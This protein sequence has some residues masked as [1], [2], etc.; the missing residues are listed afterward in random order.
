[1]S[2][3]HVQDNL[4]PSEV[5]AHVARQGQNHVEPLEISISVQSRVALRSRRLQQPDALV[6]SQRLRMQFVKLRD[7]ADHIAG[8][9]SFSAS[10]C[11]NRF[12]LSILLRDCSLPTTYYPMTFSNNSFRGSCGSSSASSFIKFRTRSS[13]GFGTMT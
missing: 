9:S 5:H 4:D 6:Q 1:H 7:R 2:F 12:S 11:H 3:A 10:W 8:F 13:V